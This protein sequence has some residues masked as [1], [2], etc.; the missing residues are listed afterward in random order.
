MRIGRALPLALVLPLLSSCGYSPPSTTVGAS[1]S[2]CR[3]EDLR[4]Y[5]AGETVALHWIVQPG[6]A[7][8]VELTAV[9]TGPYGSIDELKAGAAKGPATYAAPTLHP[10]GDVSEEPVSLIPLPPSAA[11]GIY[12]LEWAV[13]EAGG[14][15]RSAAMI[16]VVGGG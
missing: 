8:G 9:L 4:D 2:C 7:F 15:V 6:R 16:R 12:N 14:E 10:T 3:V 11:P 1:Y 13:T 5:A